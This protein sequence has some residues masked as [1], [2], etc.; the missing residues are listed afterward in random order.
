MR[1]C[2]N[3]PK[4]LRLVSESARDV[5][6]AE[7][8]TAINPTLSRHKTRNPVQPNAWLCMFCIN[9]C[10]M[11][12]AGRALA[13]HLCTG[14]LHNT[15]PD[16]YR[17]HHSEMLNWLKPTTAETKCSALQLTVVLAL[18]QRPLCMR[19]ARA[20]ERERG[21]RQALADIILPAA[22]STIQAR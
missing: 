1:A 11:A 8:H 10:V 6:T 18:A 15:R 17:C 4:A 14:G 9:S 5:A 13:F 7:L 21:S 2:L 22:R 3:H 12:C 16:Q 20:L 19:C